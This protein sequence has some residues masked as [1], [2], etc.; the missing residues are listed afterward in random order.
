MRDA[1]PA[2]GAASCAPK[3][4]IFVIDDDA[5]ARAMIAEVLR[6]GGY[7]VHAS[8]SDADALEELKHAPRPDLLVLGVLARK[9]LW[10]VGT[11]PHGASELTE[12]PTLAVREGSA[13]EADAFLPPPFGAKDLLRAVEL[14]L[15]VAADIALGAET[16]VVDVGAVLDVSLELASCELAERAHVTREFDRQLRVRANPEQLCLIFLNLLLNAAASIQQGKPEANG[17]RV[18]GWRTAEGRTVI[19]ISDSGQGM[20]PEQLVRAFEPAVRRHVRRGPGLSLARSQHIVR[21]GGG[22]IKVTSKLGSG[23]SFRVELPTA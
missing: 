21:A 13:V 18:A 15:V 14:F 3:T 16:A 12:V 11:A 6:G 17:I 2:A 4:L 5:Q 22:S 8:T 7:R 9:R 10:E 20:V 1:N 19:E 23:T